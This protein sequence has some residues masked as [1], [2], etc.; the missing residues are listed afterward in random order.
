MDGLSRGRVQ[1]EAHSVA[2]GHREVEGVA[3]Q[4]LGFCQTVSVGGLCEPTHCPAPARGQV[5][6]EQGVGDGLPR[7]GEGLDPAQPQLVGCVS[8]QLQ[9]SWR[10]RQTWCTQ[11]GGRGVTKSNRDFVKIAGQ[12][13]HAHAIQMKSTLKVHNPRVISDC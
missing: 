10:Q 9:L 4:G 2:G 3:G 5:L 6:D 12:C 1:G 8:C 7:L 13:D 11:R